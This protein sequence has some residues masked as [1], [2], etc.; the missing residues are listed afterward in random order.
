[1]PRLPTIRVIGSQFIST[2]L[3]ASAGR[4]AR[5]VVMVDMGVTPSGRVRLDAPYSIVP[6]RRWMV[7]GGQLA[8]AVPPL[9]FLVAGVVRDRPQAADHPAVDADQARRQEG[10]GRLVHE[11]HELVGEAGHGA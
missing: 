1:M 6:I 7:S 11:G 4:S 2:S 5:G 10:A 9:R 8:A 3:R